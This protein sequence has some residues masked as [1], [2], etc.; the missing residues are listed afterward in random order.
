MHK[1]RTAWP[2]ATRVGFIVAFEEA[3]RRY[4]S[5]SARRLCAVA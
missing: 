1:V 4:P 3:R 5:I 2:V